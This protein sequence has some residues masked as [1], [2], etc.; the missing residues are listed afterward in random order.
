MSENPKT[1][2]G[3]ARNRGRRATVRRPGRLGRALLILG[4]VACARA[5]T[6]QPARVVSINACTDQLA[7]LIA[8]PGQ[9]ISVSYLATAPGVSALADQARLGG[10]RLN[11][12]RAEE[13]FLLEPGLVLAGSYSGRATT[14]MLRRLGLQVEVF[15]PAASFD[16]IRANMRRMGRLLGR[17]ARADALIAEMDATLEGLPRLDASAPSAAYYGANG[18]SVGT[19]ALLHDV[20]GRGGWRNAGADFGLVSVAKLPLELLVMS[21]PDGVLLSAP[22]RGPPARAQEILRHPAL[23][24][25]AEARMEIRLADALTTCGGPFTAEAARQLAGARAAL[26]RR[27]AQ[28]ESA[29]EGSTQ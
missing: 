21:P 14:T 16:D 18:Y 11:F 2:A 13:V 20:M 19:A 29:Q 25:T 22:R 10:Y 27:R 9:L 26:L 23:R 1:R 17:E 6:A 8:E 28:E 5:G 3:A 15:P 4:L 12:G 24:H 7:M